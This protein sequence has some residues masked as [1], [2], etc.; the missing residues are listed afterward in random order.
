MGTVFIT[1]SADGLG[2]MAARRLCRRGPRGRAPRPIRGASQEALRA[3]PGAAGA[4]HGDLSSIEQ[5]RGVA[6]RPTSAAVRRGDPQRGRRLPRAAADRDRRRAQPFVRDQRARA[7]PADRADGAA[8]RGSCTSAPACIAAVTRRP[9]TC[10]G[11]RRWQ[12]AAGLLGLA[13]C[14]TRCW[15]RGRAPAPRTA[16]QLVDPAGCATKMG[17]AG[18]PDDL[19]SGAETQAWLAVSDDPAAEA[20]GRLFYHLRPMTRARRRRTSASRSSS[21]TPAGR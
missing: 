7:V 14:G 9:T 4:L 13:S 20:T 21:W 5:I 18:A 11:R 16:L 1:G 3:V 12:G 2:A 10:S 17:G 19:D 15:L 8:H 6:S